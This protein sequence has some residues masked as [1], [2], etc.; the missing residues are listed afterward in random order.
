MAELLPKAVETA[1]TDELA[2]KS[3]RVKFVAG[4]ISKAGIL[5]L[6][7]IDCPLVQRSNSKLKMADEA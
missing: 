7:V 5:F 1:R 2:K 6:E 3:R 4:E